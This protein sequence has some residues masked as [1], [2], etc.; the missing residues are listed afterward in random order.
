M[1]ATQFTLQ[2]IQ[3]CCDISSVEFILVFLLFGAVAVASG[4]PPGLGHAAM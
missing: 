2:T 1:H 3:Q 4:S